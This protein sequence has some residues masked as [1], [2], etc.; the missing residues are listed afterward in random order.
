MP[1]AQVRSRFVARA[2][3]WRAAIFAGLAAGAVEELAAM[4]L[5]P[6]FAGGGPLGLAHMT[7]AILLG[8]EVLP[9]PTNFVRVIL[10][11]LVIHFLLAV[12][13]A[14]ALAWIIE[15][16]SLPSR[17]AL[18]AGAGFGLALYIVNYHGFT[19]WFPWFAEARGAVAGLIH[20]LFGILVAWF[21]VSLAR[22]SAPA[23]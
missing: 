10:A 13:Y 12:I 16:W 11:A 7:A 14:V 2:P 21:Y 6:I 3:D 18:L 22:R 5:L 19:I 9:P 8:P 1:N 20:I 15:R 17:A 23:R 4:I